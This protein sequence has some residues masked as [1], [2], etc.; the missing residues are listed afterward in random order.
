MTSRRIR[1]G[2]SGRSGTV[3]EQRWMTTKSKEAASLVTER[4]NYYAHTMIKWYN[5]MIYTHN[6]KVVQLHDLLVYSGIQNV[7][8][9]E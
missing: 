2:S 4:G 8:H 5:Y 1:T 7:L 9:A 3:S 6:Y